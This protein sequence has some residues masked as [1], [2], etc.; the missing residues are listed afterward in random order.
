MEML[1]VPK[2]ITPHVIVR[3]LPSGT[4]APAIRPAA[5]QDW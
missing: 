1:S 2:P 4:L 3:A 5:H